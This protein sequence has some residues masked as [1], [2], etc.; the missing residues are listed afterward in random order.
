L[1]IQL[2]RNL[3]TDPFRRSPCSKSRH[4]DRKLESRDWPDI[5]D[6][7]DIRRK[8]RRRIR[9]SGLARCFRRCLPCGSANNRCCGVQ[10]RAAIAPTVRARPRHWQCRRRGNH[11]RVPPWLRCVRYGVDCRCWRHGSLGIRRDPKDPHRESTWPTSVWVEQA[12]CVCIC[13]CF[14]ERV[15]VSFQVYGRDLPV[16]ARI[17]RPQVVAV[18]SIVG[19]PVSNNQRV[20]P[21]LR[22]WTLR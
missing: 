13:L 20:C 5:R 4:I 8:Y 21:C 7:S 1:H 14:F 15:C 9:R 12:Y 3:R 6:T 16:S 10:P 22:R 17:S 11:V 18:Q 2:R 19:R